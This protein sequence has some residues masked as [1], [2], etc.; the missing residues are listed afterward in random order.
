MDQKVSKDSFK[1]YRDWHRY[2]LKAKP[3]LS[4]GHTKATLLAYCFA[5]A[6]HGANGLGCYASDRVIAG[7][8]GMYDFR[9]ALPYRN[10]AV[11]LG[12][13]VWN[14]KRKGRTKVLDIAIPADNENV[15]TDTPAVTETPQV[16]AD[17]HVSGYPVDCPAC[18][19]HQRSIERG[20]AYPDMPIWQIHKEA[21]ERLCV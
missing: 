16:S 6:S 5:M 3:K 9:S 18:Q 4:D 10:E 19:E 14:G 12:W 15:W 20:L 8:L 7:E 13:F 21:L 1:A 11:R 2:I 17:G